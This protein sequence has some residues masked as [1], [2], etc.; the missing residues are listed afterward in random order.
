[1]T[2]LRLPPL[3]SARNAKG[4]DPFALACEAAEV[5]CD[6][7]LVIYDL[8][9]AD[10]RAAIVFAP[11]VPLG[12][13]AAMLPIC[14]VGFQNAL[15]ALAPPEVGVHLGWD[16]G[17]Y[18]N[19]GRA[20]HFAMAAS[21]PDPDVEPDWLVVALT[22]SLW[23]KNDDTGLTPDQTALYSEG[24]ADVAPDQLLEAWVRH[25]LVGIN[26]WSDGG[27]AKLHAE[28][29]GLA[30]ALKGEMTVAGQTGTYIGLDEN[31]GLLLKIDQETVLI[32]LTATL[33]RPA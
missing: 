13:A 3:F 4:G 16:G 24:C 14:G 20:G 23:P 30:H 27:M 19:G 25:T 21:R 29:S 5:G 10:L 18:L 12:D 31:L 32:P 8:G 15:G 17:I 2:T 6:A 11:D 9:A 22:L 26:S 33:T 1:M 7:G 28:W